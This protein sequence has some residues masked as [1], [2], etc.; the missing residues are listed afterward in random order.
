MTTDDELDHAIG[1]WL[2]RKEA[3]PDLLPGT[4]ANELAPALREPFLRELEELAEIDGLATLAPPRDLPRRFGDFR[5]L[6]ELGRGAMGVVYDAEQVST[7]QRVALKVMHAHVAKDLHS[8]SRFQREAHTAASLQHPGIVRV[9]GFG[10]TDG[11]AWLAMERLEGCSLQRLLAA[12]GVPRDVDHASARA[13]FHDSKNLVRVLADAADALE[14]AHRNG[15]VHRD[16]KPAN[17]VYGAGRVVVL[18]F[19]L[20]KAFDVDAAT[21]TRTG[22][23]LGTPL[24]MAPEQAIGAENV[25]PQTDVYSLGAVLYECLCGRPPVPPGPLAAVIDAILNRDAVDPRRLRP[26][27]PEQLSRIALQCL[28]KEP[29]RRY[30]TAADLAD[31]L[32]RFVDGNAVLARHDGVVSRSLRRLRRRPAIMA[33]LAVVC[34]AV[35]AVVISWRQAAQSDTRAASL[36]R[37][38]ST[39][40]VDEL[41]G[42]APERI[43]VFGGASLRYYSR[44]GLGEQTIGGASTRSAAAEEALRTA[45]ELVASDPRELE[46]LR[47]L[48]RA[49]MDVGDDS[50]AT[51][52]AIAALLAHPG[53][54]A[55]DRMMAAVHAR[56][57]G[58]E[59]EAQRLRAGLDDRDAGVAFWLGFWHQDEQDHD[60]AIAAFTRALDAGTLPGELRYQ[61]LLHRGWCRTCPDVARPVEACD[62][63]L[64][65]SALRPRYGTPLLLWAA[66]RCLQARRLGDLDE[67]VA[68]VV[69]VLGGAEPWV[70]VLTARVL[71][72]LAEGGTTQSGP[73]CFGAEWSP[74]AVVPVPAAI[75]NALAATALGLLDG[76]LSKGDSFEPAFHRVAGLALAGRHADALAAADRLQASSPPARHALVD[77]QRARVHL[78]A[79]SPK[80]AL[81]ALRSALDKDKDLLAA[82]LL[83]AR[84]CAHVGDATAQLEATVRAIEL[85]AT[86]A[87]ETSVFPDAAV[88]L[89]ELQLTRARLLADLGRKGEAIEL[90]RKGD[91]GGALAGEFSLRVRLQR[92]LLLQQL[93]AEALSGV[94]APGPSSPLRWLHGAGAPSDADTSC[95]LAAVRRDW[96]PGGTL[97]AFAARD[98]CCAEQLQVRGLRAPSDVATAPLQ[99]LIANAIALAR[100]PAS[101][102]AVI[103]RARAESARDGDNGEAR[104]LHALMLHL[105]HQSEAKAALAAAAQSLPDDLRVRY[106]LAV[107]ARQAGDRELL[108]STLSR[109]RALLSEHEIDAAAKALPLPEPVRGVT[110]LDVLR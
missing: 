42:A 86:S 4:F 78:A 5:L 88:Q 94:A 100:V 97:E 104:L 47:V 25:T 67:P 75:A 101:A 34:I 13:L 46:A 23:F 29:E 106:L 49:R 40:R 108:E 18:D 55:G 26:G 92:N 58:R 31:D 66:L 99:V 14:F 28:A 83:R 1:D 98:A 84:V 81:Q 38:V 62:D 33:L 103:E 105:T 82:W 95:M 37:V 89:P 72:A 48:A 32:R 71:L 30:A 10:E 39:A 53:V 77:L 6:G 50:A 27:V 74:I 36:Q 80:L 16:I 41:L 60:A 57:R 59:A 79:G 63:L 51:D 69:K 19:G 22:D 109:G 107:V 64:Q 85:L 68:A 3:E 76:V 17:L 35:L 20:A 52:R 2:L 61:A 90:L 9:L 102:D 73:V 96:L 93:G 87:R 7:R 8:A 70:H 45:E 65:A 24:Y 21:L 91:F 56:Q 12:H 11:A 15:V 44:L 54:T 43:T 110:L